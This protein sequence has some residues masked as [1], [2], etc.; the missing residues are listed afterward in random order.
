MGLLRAEIRSNDI[1]KELGRRARKR[2]AD[3]VVEA[4]WVRMLT[5]VVARKGASAPIGD[6]AETGSH[7]VTGTLVRFVDPA[8]NY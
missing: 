8:C 3:A 4:S 1:K 6:P 2:G 5:V 7:S